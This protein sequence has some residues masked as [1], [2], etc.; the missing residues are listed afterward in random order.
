M[1]NVV[2]LI[3]IFTFI[4]NLCSFSQEL[5]IDVSDFGFE[6]VEWPFTPVDFMNISVV[7][8]GATC[9]KLELSIEGLE[10]LFSTSELS[11]Y[12]K[13]DIRN[14]NFWVGFNESGSSDWHF[15]KIFY[16]DQFNYDIS[17][18]RLKL[19]HDLITH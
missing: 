18:V 12:E 8:G 6:N 17:S 7:S 16:T 5:E 2:K 19:R 1:K 13:N 15:R 3:F 10:D 11:S 9:E 14:A 4:L